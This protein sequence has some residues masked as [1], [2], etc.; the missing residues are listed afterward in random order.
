MFPV[1]GTSRASLRCLTEAVVRALEYIRREARAM[2]VPATNR[3]LEVY[4]VSVK[5]FAAVTCKLRLLRAD[6]RL[7]LCHVPGQGRPRPKTP[8]IIPQPPYKKNPPPKIGEGPT[9]NQSTTTN[10]FVVFL[11]GMTLRHRPEQSHINAPWMV[12]CCILQI[13]YIDFN[14]FHLGTE[15]G[16]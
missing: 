1:F 5:R 7:R 2:R 16:R 8:Q 4:Y 14:V 10:Y 11:A 15:R 6:A 12:G 13:T 9:S 3:I